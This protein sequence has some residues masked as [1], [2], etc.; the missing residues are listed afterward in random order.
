MIRRGVLK[1]ASIGLLLFAA[2]ACSRAAPPPGASTV[3][4]PRICASVRRAATG[5]DRIGATGR[6]VVGQPF[7]TIATVAWRTPDLPTG[8]VRVSEDDGPSKLLT[9]AAKGGIA[10]INWIAVGHTYLFG[11]YPTMTSRA[12]LAS[13]AVKQC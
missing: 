13:V 7:G 10:H 3:L 4:L 11:L 9:G 8:V 12:P 6:T 1:Y 2:F 5:P